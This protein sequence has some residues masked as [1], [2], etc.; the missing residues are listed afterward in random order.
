MSD[1]NEI[2]PSGPKNVSDISET[3]YM[4]VRYIL[5]RDKAGTDRCY[6]QL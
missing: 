4:L 2:E 1:F 5:G 3:L 6:V